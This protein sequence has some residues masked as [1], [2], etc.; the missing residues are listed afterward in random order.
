MS[1][2]SPAPRPDSPTRGKLKIFLGYAAGVGKTY[3]MLVEA[4][5]LQAEGIDVVIGYFEPHGRLDTIA[6]AE[7]LESVP[8]R[9]VEHRGTRLEEMDTDAI[10]QRRPQVCVVDEFAHTNVPGS[11]RGKRWEDVM[12]L[13]AAG[14]NVLTSLNVQHIE[15]LNDQVWQVTG[16][17][18]RETIPD[19]VVQE[20]DDVVMV[21]LTPRALLHRLERGVVYAPDKAQR[22]LE[23]FFTESNLTALREL[24]LRQTAHQIEDRREED[25]VRS[26]S[27]VLPKAGS[28]GSERILLWLTADPATA[29]L[30]RRG[31]RV[32]DYLQSACVAVALVNNCSADE[33]GAIERHLNFAR[34][35]RIEAAT[36][37]ATNPAEAIAD[38]ARRNQITQIFVT[39]H[40]PDLQKLVR[41][42]RDM[43]VTIVSERTR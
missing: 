9:I 37:S 23:N 27:P 6:K 43:Q 32:A 31:R 11:E 3:Q 25:Q 42:V 36:L 4:H 29:M 21:D 10:L 14:V 38:Y 18:V 2:S 39:R 5:Q 15:S 7:G 34:N 40:V 1:E 8:R 41:L 22:A 17:R 19:W 20:A 35:M 30:I 13:R 24:A 12:I 16:I 26:P 33:R 28:T